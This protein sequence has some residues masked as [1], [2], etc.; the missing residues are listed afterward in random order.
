[1][2]PENKTRFHAIVCALIDAGQIVPTDIISEFHCEWY[3][4]DEGKNRII[5]AAMRCGMCE[6][7]S[8][9]GNVLAFEVDHLDCATEIANGGQCAGLGADVTRKVRNRIFMD[10]ETGE[11]ISNKELWYAFK[12]HSNKWPELYATWESELDDHSPFKSEA[13]E[14][15]HFDNIERTKDMRAA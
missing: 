10:F 14:H 1:M 4:T 15:L 7:D 8:L 5:T 12:N 11:Y 9:V 3:A 2:N 6:V 13:D